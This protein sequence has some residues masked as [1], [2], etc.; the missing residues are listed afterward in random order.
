MVTSNIQRIFFRI[1]FKLLYHSAAWSYDL[2]AAI[3]SANKWSEWMLTATPFL[4]GPRI[5]ELG[6]GPGH[7]QAK[8]ISLKY[9]VFGIDESLQMINLAR[10]KIEALARKADQ[11]HDLRISRAKAQYLPFASEIFD[12]IVSTFPTEYIFDPL[13]LSEIH[14]VLVPGGK[15]IIIL[16]SEV[17]GRKLGERLAAWLSRTTHQSADWNADFNTFFKHPGLETEILIKDLGTSRV[18]IVKAIKK[19]TPIQ[20]D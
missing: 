9:V 20:P 5:L 12:S 8:L 17:T 4:S 2:V 14:R 18:L 1:A 15:A 11:Q 7:L 19:G 16:G 10:H 6:F 13:A 3:A